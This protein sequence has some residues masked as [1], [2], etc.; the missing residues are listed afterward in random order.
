LAPWR[1]KIV[2]FSGGFNLFGALGLY[3]VAIASV[4]RAIAITQEH[5]SA[6]ELVH[7]RREL[8]EKQAMPPPHAA[9]APATP[10]P[11]D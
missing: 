5:V 6:A 9:S 2:L 8:V 1:F 4:D 11:I 7:F 10:K 3:L